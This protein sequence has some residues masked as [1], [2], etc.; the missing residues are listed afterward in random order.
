[1][2][3]SAI[4]ESLYTQQYYATNY[5]Q[6]AQMQVDIKYINDPGLLESYGTKDIN[7]SSSVFSTLAL[8]KE[9]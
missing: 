3:N 2:G 5:F 4:F 9:L 7:Y 6:N 1:M 8:A